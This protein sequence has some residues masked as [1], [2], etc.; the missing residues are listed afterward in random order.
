MTRQQLDTSIPWIWPLINPTTGQRMDFEFH[1]GGYGY[2]LFIFGAGDRFRP[3]GALASLSAFGHLGYASAYMW[4]DPER[5]LAG[6]YLYVSPRL[7]RD[8]PFT[9]SDLFQNAV[10]A[11]I[12]D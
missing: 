7:H 5:E 1:G 12:V 3:N 11:A 8:M 6:V 9:N 4:A 2:G 10:H